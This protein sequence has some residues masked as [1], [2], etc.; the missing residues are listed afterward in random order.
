MR[1]SLQVREIRLRPE[2]DQSNDV[3]IGILA[4]TQYKTPRVI[5][6]VLDL[7]GPASVNCDR[8]R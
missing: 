6:S 1:S 8:V 4:V 2:A 5:T 7:V 3:E